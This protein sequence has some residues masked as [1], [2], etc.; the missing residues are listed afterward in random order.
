MDADNG[1]HRRYVVGNQDWGKNAENQDCQVVHSAGECER[2]LDRSENGPQGLNL[3]A[4][5]SRSS[6]LEGSVI[7]HSLVADVAMLG[8]VPEDLD[9]IR[10]RG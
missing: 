1:Y 10:S 2:C 8:V 9:H 3:A 4:K 7:D 6:N 5:E